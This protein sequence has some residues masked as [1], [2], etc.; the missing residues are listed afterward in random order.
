MASDKPV[1][2]KMDT[3]TKVLPEDAAFYNKRKRK[4]KEGERR[5]ATETKVVGEEKR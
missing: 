3:E 1:D 2:R 5:Q 4:T